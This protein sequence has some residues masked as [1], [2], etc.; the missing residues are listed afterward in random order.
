MCLRI[1]AYLLAFVMIGIDKYHTKKREAWSYF[2]FSKFFSFVGV[3][4][5]ADP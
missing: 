1:P 3:N 5:E 2:S 4:Y